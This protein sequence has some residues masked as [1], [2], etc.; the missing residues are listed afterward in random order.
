LKSINTLKPYIEAD[1]AFES[2]RIF[3]ER[4]AAA[5]MLAKHGIELPED[6]TVV[7]ELVAGLKGGATKL[8]EVGYS[9]L[10][11]VGGPVALAGFGGV[12]ICGLVWL[13]RS[14]MDSAADGKSGVNRSRAGSRSKSKKAKVKRF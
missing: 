13:T 5:R 3:S 12:S 10:E 8:A 9:A 6:P 14:R 7:D 4:E 11:L 1:Y 2:P